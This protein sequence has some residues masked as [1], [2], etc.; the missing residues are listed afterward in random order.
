MTT[1]S[2]SFFKETRSSVVLIIYIIYNVESVR[3]AGQ[4]LLQTFA[5]IINILS[6][7]E[8]TLSNHI[9]KTLDIKEINANKIPVY[10]I[11]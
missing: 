10:A 8:A 3:L 4:A 7:L 2:Y 9:S 1:N 11:N 6:I 5:F